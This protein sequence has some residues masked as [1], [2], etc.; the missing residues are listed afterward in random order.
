ML[1]ATDDTFGWARS[2]SIKLSGNPARQ[3]RKPARAHREV[4]RFCHRQRIAG[5]GYAGIHQDSIDSKLQDAWDKASDK[6]KQ[7]E[8]QLKAVGS[9][10]VKTG[11]EVGAWTT[12][13]PGTA[14]EVSD[15]VYGAAQR[16]FCGKEVSV[17]TAQPCQEL[18]MILVGGVSSK[19]IRKLD[20][21]IAALNDA[22]GFV[23]GA[24]S[25]S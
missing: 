17:E 8:T 11:I 2:R 9:Q 14:A 6:L 20:A 23:P 19:E 7:A 10:P 25:G 12:R 22:Y 24:V 5:G 21:T 15:T 13:I 4:H 1:Q 18:R 16:E 3:I